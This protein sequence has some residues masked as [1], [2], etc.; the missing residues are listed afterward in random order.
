M[1]W[2][3][4]DSRALDHS[5][6]VFSHVDD[7]RKFMGHAISADPRTCRD[8]TARV[9]HL[10]NHNATAIGPPVVVD[11]LRVPICRHPNR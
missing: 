8:K 10:D 11:S 6:C 9:G 3:C 5:R 4:D 1:G 7:G 2:S